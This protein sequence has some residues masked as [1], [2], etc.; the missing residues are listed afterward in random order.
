MEH[1]LYNPDGY[2]ALHEKMFDNPWVRAQTVE[3]LFPPNLVQPKLELPYRP[4][5]TWSLTGG[6]HSAWGPDGAIVSHRPGATNRQNLAAR[7][8][9]IMLLQWLQVWY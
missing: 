7:R 1:N 2:P 3:P 8:Q 5:H 9:R 6:P 4:G